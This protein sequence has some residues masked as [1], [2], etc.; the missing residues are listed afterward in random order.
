MEKA[1][2]Q[3][4]RDIEKLVDALVDAPKV[5]RQRIA[6]RMEALDA[7]KVELEADTARLR[8]ASEIQLTESEIRAWLHT[9]TQ[10]DPTDENFRRR[11][12]DVFINTVY[13]YDDRVLIFYN[14]RGGK[15]V[16]YIDLLNSLYV[17]AQSEGSDLKA[18]GVPGRIRALR[19]TKCPKALWQCGRGQGG[20]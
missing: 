2:A 14:I 7:Q 18:L 10:G 20:G 16:S 12:I 13:L 11:V 8:V 4:D 5:A 6:D 17:P 1:I 9:F 3:I 15:Q 19:V